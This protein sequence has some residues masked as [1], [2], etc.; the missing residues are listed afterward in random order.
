MDSVQDLVTSSDE[1]AELQPTENPS[2][3][4]HVA[5]PMV[6]IKCHMNA[7]GSLQR[8]CFGLSVLGYCRNMAAQHGGLR[9]RGPAP[10]VT[11]VLYASYA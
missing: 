4:K 5:E 11:Q 6:A 2:L 10:Y 7:K 8:Q 3:I 9:G 1:V